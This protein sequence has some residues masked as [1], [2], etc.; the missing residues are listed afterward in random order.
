MRGWYVE[1]LIDAAGQVI[2]E[3]LYTAG[4]TNVKRPGVFH[5]IKQV[6]PGGV[7][8]LVIHDLPTGRG[9]FFNV[10]GVHVPWREYLRIPKK[11]NSEA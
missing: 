11:N 8:T 6:S 9:W 2:G 4:M 3:K 10:D 5:R 7:L 1:E